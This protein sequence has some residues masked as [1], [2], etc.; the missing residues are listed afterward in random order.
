M[1][2]RCPRAPGIYRFRART[3]FIFYGAAVIATRRPCRSGP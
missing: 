1:R 2:G 3:S